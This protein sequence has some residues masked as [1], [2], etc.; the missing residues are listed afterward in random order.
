MILS[1]SARLAKCCCV[2]TSEAALF[3][4][5]GT[6]RKGRGYT[7]IGMIHSIVFLMLLLRRQIL[8]V[9]IAVAVI[10]LGLCFYAVGVL[11]TMRKDALLAAISNWQNTTTEEEEKME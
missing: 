2:V 5:L 10:A 7:V 4:A 9:P 6:L 1:G 3:W 11:V 8:S